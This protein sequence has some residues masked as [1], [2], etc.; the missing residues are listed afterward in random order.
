MPP[1][2]PPF[3][4]FGL[5]LSRLSSSNQIEVPS[6]R[7]V[8]STNATVDFMKTVD[9]RSESYYEYGLYQSGDEDSSVNDDEEEEDLWFPKPF[10]AGLSHPTSAVCM[11]AVGVMK[12]PCRYKVVPSKL[13]NLWAV[14]LRSLKRKTFHRVATL[15]S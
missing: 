11:S 10:D 15:T 4:S 3:P 1:V 13:T 12:D 6:L 2:Q 9:C 14:L 7:T 5:A 8:A